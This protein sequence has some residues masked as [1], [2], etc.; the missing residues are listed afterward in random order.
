M[1]GQLA[2]QLLGSP[3]VPQLG[4]LPQTE[5]NPP[6]STLCSL[7]TELVKSLPEGSVLFIVIDGIHYYE[8]DARREECK[9]VL[10]TMTEL[11]RGRPGDTNNGPLIKLLVTD[12][13]KSHDVQRLFADSDGLD[14]DS[15]IERSD[16]STESRWNMR[17]SG[18]NAAH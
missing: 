9:E 6:L 16:G 13:L 12:S 10:S 1:V 5:E 8:D 17:M 11:A 2:S 4:H 15:Y 7:F 3:L 18:T 14:L